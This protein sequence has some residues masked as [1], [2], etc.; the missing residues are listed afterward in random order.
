MIIK[1]TLILSQRK[2][3]N[4]GRISN[5]PDKPLREKLLTFEV[6]R[7]NGFMSITIFI[8]GTVCAGRGGLAHG[9]VYAATFLGMES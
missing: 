5:K 6:K 4:V 9:L 2:K 7:V 1:E 3:V 8:C